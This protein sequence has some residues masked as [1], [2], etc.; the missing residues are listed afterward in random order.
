[1]NIYAYIFILSVL[2]LLRTLT[3]TLPFLVTL[4]GQEESLTEVHT[5]GDTTP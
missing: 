3:N 5:T 2:F 4:R 1:M